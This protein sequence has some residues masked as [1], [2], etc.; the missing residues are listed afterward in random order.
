MAFNFSPKVVTDG[1]VLYLDAAN[2]KSI[3][4]GSTTWTDLSR[5]NNNGTLVNGPT[6]NSGSGGNI[7]FNGSN[8]SV[9]C[10]DT[11]SYQNSFTFNLVFKTTT[12]T[13]HVLIGKY[14][15]G[16]ADFWVG[17]SSGKLAFSFG[18]PSKITLIS[19]MNINDGNWQIATAV[20][21]R[22]LN[23]T[24]IYINGTQNSSTNSIPT[25]IQ[26]PVGNLRLATFGDYGGPYFLSGSIAQFQIYNR[27]L[28]SQEVLQNYNATKTRFGL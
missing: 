17:T 3:V 10:G 14:N 4:S 24:L 8:T 28:S 2:S 11:L 6:F 25:T 16:G 15:G 13:I 1:L 18:S 26:E 19:T 9:N 12:S 7:V 21:N 20:F 27:A 22:S 5:S 23:Q